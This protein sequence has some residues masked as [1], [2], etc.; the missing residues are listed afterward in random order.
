MGCAG[1]SRFQLWVSF[2]LDTFVEI[3]QSSSASV[4]IVPLFLENTY[5]LQIDDRDLNITS[6]SMLEEEHSGTRP[7][8]CIQHIPTGISVQ[9]AA[10]FKGRG[11]GMGQELEKAR[12]KAGKPLP[13]LTQTLISHWVNLESGNVPDYI[14]SWKQFHTCKEKEEFVNEQ[15]KTDY[16][17]MYKDFKAQSQ[18]VPSSISD[19]GNTVDEMMIMR[20][21]LGERPG[22]ERGVDR[23]L[24]GKKTSNSQS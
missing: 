20:K 18:Q 12:R 13:I 22:L 9:S 15:A 14:E 19:E 1:C 11:G 4:D 6:S 7:S 24:N 23:T 16:E 21:V 8:V 2:K 3:M 10:P 5:N 17:I